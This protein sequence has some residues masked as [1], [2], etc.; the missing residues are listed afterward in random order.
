MRTRDTTT[1]LT[2]WSIR[3]RHIRDDKNP[4]VSFAIREWEG[5]VTLKSLDEKL[6]DPIN[7]KLLGLLPLL[8][9]RW[10][11]DNLSVAD[12]NSPQKRAAFAKIIFDKKLHPAIRFFRS[13]ILFLAAFQAAH[14]PDTKYYKEYKRQLKL[15]RRSE[16]NKRKKV[17]KLRNKKPGL[18][19]IAGIASTSSST[20][21][22]SS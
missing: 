7:R 16:Q 21:A 10:F 8:G 17:K 3:Y 22:S 4:A 18:I 2:T 19:K 12:I 9:Q 13:H 14:K 5:G 1:A 15:I 11:K 6:T 20:E